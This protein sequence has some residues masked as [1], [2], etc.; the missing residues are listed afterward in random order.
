L[1]GCLGCFLVTAF[2]GILF[3]LRVLLPCYLLLV[4]VLVLDE[5]SPDDLAWLARLLGISTPQPASGEH[6]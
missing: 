1:L 6:P 4:C 2:F 5:H 3:E